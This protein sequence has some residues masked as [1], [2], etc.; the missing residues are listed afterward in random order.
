MRNEL[1]QKLQQEE[2]IRINY[3]KA[4]KIKNKKIR[5]KKKMIKAAQQLKLKKIQDIKNWKKEDQDRAT[6]ALK[7][8]EEEAI[9][10]QEQKEFDSELKKMKLIESNINPFGFVLV[11]VTLL[12]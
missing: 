2:I 12:F 1:H 7:E 10:K 3:F 8:K 5:K 9:A 6:N 11:L 4:E